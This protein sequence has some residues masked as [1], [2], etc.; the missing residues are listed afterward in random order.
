[1]AEAGASEPREHSD[2]LPSFVFGSNTLN[3]VLEKSTNQKCQWTH[4]CP[5]K[6]EGKGCLPKWKTFR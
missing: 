4:M 2:E 6:K 1:M 3:W 5:P